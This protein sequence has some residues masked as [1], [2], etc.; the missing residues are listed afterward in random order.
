MG[1]QAPHRLGPARVVLVPGLV[2]EVLFH[3]DKSG[4]EA[5]PAKIAR[6]KIPKPPPA[7][8]GADAGGL[9]DAVA[10]QGM[11]KSTQGPTRCQPLQF[12]HLIGR[13]E[14]SFILHVDIE[15]DDGPQR[16]AGPIPDRVPHAVDPADA[17][18]S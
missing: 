6:P 9:R 7:F 14:I 16:G 11:V 10:L 13:L 4:G 18:V 15:E 3:A 17:A 5:F 12:G 1:K 2:V 8:F